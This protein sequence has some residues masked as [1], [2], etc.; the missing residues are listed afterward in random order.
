MLIIPFLLKLDKSIFMVQSAAMTLTVTTIVDIIQSVLLLGIL[1]FA[2][3]GHETHKRHAKE[4][5]TREKIIQQQRSELN[6]LEGMYR[7][8]LGISEEELTVKHT[9]KVEVEH[10]KEEP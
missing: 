6:K 5:A 8:I 10:T 1:V 2:A 7:A 3:Q 9:G 4:M